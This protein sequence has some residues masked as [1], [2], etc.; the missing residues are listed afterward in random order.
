MPTIKVFYK[1]QRVLRFVPFYNLWKDLKVEIKKKI[2]FN[3]NRVSIVICY[4]RAGKQQRYIPHNELGGL[5]DKR[6]NVSI[7]IFDLEE[8]E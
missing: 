3:D 2:D 4:K 6:C 7:Y 5:P 1:G 8:G